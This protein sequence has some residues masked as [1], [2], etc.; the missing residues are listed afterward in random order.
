MTHRCPAPGCQVK[1]PVEQLACKPHWY[2]IPKPLRDAV[3]H[4]YR[5]E[6]PGSQPHAAAI[7]AAIGYLERRAS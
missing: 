1:V 4:T 6:G 2:S 7:D 3:W 5:H